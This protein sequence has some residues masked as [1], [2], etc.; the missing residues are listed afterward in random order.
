MKP[1]RVEGQSP[2]I[3]SADDILAKMR[4]GKKQ[5]FEMKLGDQ[6]I[7]VRVLTID[8][9][10]AIR[11]EALAHMARVGGDET[12]KNVYIQKT[13]LKVASTMSEGSG[14]LLSD[15]LLGKLS[16]DEISYLYDEYVKLMDQANPTLETISSEHFRVL[17]EAVK[18]NLV[19]SKDLSLVQLKAIFTA[20]Q[21]LI[22]KQ[23]SQTSQAGN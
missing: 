14:P 7:P 18:K 2:G 9:T 1:E 11:R 16:L 21:D 22:Q 12:D 3:T 17:V 10:T 5:A 4:A 6:L 23:E 13:S 15:K 8:E 19:S 20:F